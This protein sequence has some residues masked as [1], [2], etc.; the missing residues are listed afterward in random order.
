MGADVDRVRRL[1]SRP[2]EELPYAVADDELT[3]VTVAS[4]EWHGAARARRRAPSEPDF[5]AEPHQ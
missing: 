1:L 3:A 4:E 5:F 2:T